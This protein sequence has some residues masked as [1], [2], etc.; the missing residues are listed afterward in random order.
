MHLRGKHTSTTIELL[1][2]TLFSICIR[3]MGFY[4][5]NS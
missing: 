1:L 2:E 3:A 4:K 5:K